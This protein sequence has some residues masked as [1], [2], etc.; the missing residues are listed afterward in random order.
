MVTYL[1][2]VNQVQAYTGA[3]FTSVSSILQV[4]S[5]TKTDAFSGT[6][7]SFVDVTGLSATIT[8]T[9]SSNKIYV[10]FSGSVAGAGGNPIYG[11]L[12]RGSTP[13]SV[14]ATVGSRSSVTFNFPGGNSAHPY[15]ASAVIVDS[16]NTTSAVT[17]KLQLR[18]N[19]ATA[20]YVNRSVDDTNDPNFPRTAATIT[21]ME[22][23]G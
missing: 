2:D 20:F 15:I 12:L 4:V 10:S 3:A 19:G 11:L 23:A 5:T 7:S 22:V 8:P 9:S 6:G 17:Y 21:L 16:P 14:G 1:S 13:I 18:S